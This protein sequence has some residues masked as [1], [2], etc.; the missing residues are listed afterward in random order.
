MVQGNIVFS[1]NHKIVNVEKSN[2]FDNADHYVV[3]MPMRLIR[4]K[5]LHTADDKYTYPIV[6]IST[7]LY[8]MGFS[9]SSNTDYR[10]AIYEYK[11]IDRVLSKLPHKVCYKTYPE[12]N[13]RYADIDPIIRHVDSADNIDLFS[14]K[15]DMR[16]LVSKYK[17]LITTCA[18]STLGWPV[19]SGKP[20]VFINR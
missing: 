8:H 18:T 17:I 6:F 14:E 7:N 9:I 12:D 1:Y 5:N 16:Y 4:M 15:I 13:R 2:Y 19:M 10:N 20:V 3:G 11:I